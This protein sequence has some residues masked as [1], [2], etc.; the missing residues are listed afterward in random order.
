MSNPEKKKMVRRSLATL[1]SGIY[2]L[3]GRVEEI[4]KLL[5]ISPGSVESEKR[6][7]PPQSGT[8]GLL[9]GVLEETIYI[10]QIFDRELDAILHELERI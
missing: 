10:V 3:G 7:K 5:G 6:G 1:I 4:S 8:I 9:L 2:Q